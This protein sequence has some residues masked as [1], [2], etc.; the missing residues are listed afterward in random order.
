MEPYRVTASCVKVL[1][2]VWVILI[3]PVIIKSFYYLQNNKSL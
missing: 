2:L 1:F 3:N